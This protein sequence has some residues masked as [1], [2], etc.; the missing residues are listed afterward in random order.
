MGAYRLSNI[1]DDSGRKP[2]IGFRMDT[3]DERTLLPEVPISA[4]DPT[5]SFKPVSHLLQSGPSPGR[6]PKLCNVTGRIRSH[7]GE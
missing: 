2:I 5:L 3:T 4:I 1:L 6:K 7:G